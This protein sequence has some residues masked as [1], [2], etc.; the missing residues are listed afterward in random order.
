MTPVRTK[1]FI[2]TKCGEKRKKMCYISDTSRKSKERRN[3]LNINF[4]DTGV[5]N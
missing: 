2:T 3:I 4:S 5:P 1:P